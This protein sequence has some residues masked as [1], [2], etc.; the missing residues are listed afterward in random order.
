MGTNSLSLRF[1]HTPAP[2][3]RVLLA[4][5]DG[6]TISYESSEIAFE[7]APGT[8]GDLSAEA[9]L[10]GL[11]LALSPSVSGL[12]SA[13]G[14]G[15]A[16]AYA[17]GSF[18]LAWRDGQARLSGA[19]GLEVAVPV[20]ASVGPLT[21]RT[22]HARLEVSD[23]GIALESSLDIDISVAGGIEV[24]IQRVGISTALNG[25][26]LSNGFPLALAPHPPTGG[27]LDLDLGI[28]SGGGFLS[29]DEAAGQYAGV[30]AARM[31][32]IGVD[33]TAI[34]NTK[35]PPDGHSGFSLLAMLSAN[36]RPLGLELSF[37]FTLNA[38]GGLLGVNRCC[39]AEQLRQGV[40]TGAIESMM[41]PADPIRNAPR[42]IADLSRFFPPA[43]GQVVI[44][45]MLELGWG[46]PAGMIALRLA[47]ILQVPDPLI[48]IAG[49][50]ILELP[51]TGG[52]ALI[53]IQVAF[54]GGIDPGRSRVTFDA[55]LIDSH[56]LFATLEGDMALRF[57]YAGNTDF[58]VSAGGFFPRWQPP[59]DLSVGT[60][61]RMA[62][63][64]S[65]IGPVRIRM[66]S[67]FAVSSNTV[68]HGGHLEMRLGV[69]G[70]G[71]SGAIGY[72]V[73]IVFDPFGFTAS[74]GAS[75]KVEAFGATICSVDVNGELTGPKPL[76][77]KGRGS[78][79]VLFARISVPVDVTIGSSPNLPP[80]TVKVIDLLAKA[81][82][83][84]GAAVAEL[85]P[86]NNGGL[87]R[88]RDGV[89]GEP[90]ALQ[91]DGLVAV[92]QAIVPLAI[93]IDRVGGAKPED[94]S[95]FDIIGA[96]SDG[97]AL[98]VT[99]D[100]PL[101]TFSPS[102]FFNL[103]EDQKLS[104]RAFEDHPAGVR[105]GSDGRPSFSGVCQADFD[106]EAILID[107]DGTSYPFL[108]RQ[109]SSA[110]TDS[111][112]A[113]GIAA[114]NKKERRVAEPQIQEK[115]ENFVL[116]DVDTGQTLTQPAT[117]HAI[118]GMMVDRLQIQ[119]ALRDSIRVVSMLDLAA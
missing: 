111:L 99:P 92:T 47:L 74:I 67:Y 94:G 77:L 113:G 114:Q 8:P 88:M 38:V 33:A 90:V 27:G 32:G 73:I 24:S 119:P 97:V 96:T 68:Q 49:M 45:P 78:F 64:I 59:A 29:I 57:R 102:Q 4:S 98:A 79:K 44:A 63:G 81:L 107:S 87:V 58:I 12:L 51:R 71:V 76:R 89:T 19:G 30:F 66:E 105:I 52:A 34:V 40:R 110:V 37:G 7:A 65:G 104:R 48:Q 53:R 3:D 36:F 20:N 39:D 95:T 85:P 41:F 26:D 50:L 42:I 109:L 86:G 100:R 46:K 93:R 13:L 21:A 6:S 25:F 5:P 55:S 11:S 70:Y 23:G 60:L 69:D 18:G 103:T 91:P 56:L 16:A 14:G 117:A 43:D 22:F 35:L 75:F 101:S 106:A 115:V 61:R 17:V 15:A 116:V 118:Q 9:R 62:V 1:P 2:A 54:L 82:S 83:T 84:P 108:S 112:L 28:V 31:L 80:V 72:D 10:N